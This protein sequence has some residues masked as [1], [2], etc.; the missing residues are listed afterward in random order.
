M[1][2]D[3]REKLRNISHRIMRSEFADLTNQELQFYM[4]RTDDNKIA[5][6]KARLEYE[7]RLKHTG[8]IEQEKANKLSENNIKINKWGLI[9]S[10]I[11]AFIAIIISVFAY[12]KP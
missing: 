4:Q 10:A 9:I 3:E 5:N 7:T 8:I 2:E 6:K 12:L 11:L 1:Q